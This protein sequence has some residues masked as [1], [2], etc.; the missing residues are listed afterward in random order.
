VTV[1]RDTPPP[2]EEAQI[3]Y[4]Q[5]G[6]WTD[7]RTRRRRTVW[8]FVMVFAHNRHVFVRPTLSMDQ[9]EW[10]AAHVEAFAFFG[11]V[12]ARL[13]SDNL[14]TGGGQPDLY[15]RRSIGRVPS[16]PRIMGC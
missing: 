6:M 2:G 15:D 5:L 12:T 14:E 7:P 8:A 9:R 16:W 11:G 10:T 1:L 13:V 4:G 3:N